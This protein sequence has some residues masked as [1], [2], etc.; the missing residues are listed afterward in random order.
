MENDPV[1]YR[2]EL[3]RELADTG[4]LG[5]IVPEALGGAAL[6]AIEVAIT[7]EELGRALCWT[8]HFTTAVLGAS[9]IQRGGA[10]AQQL[11][12][13][14]AVASGQAV[15]TTAWLEPEGGS[16]PAGVQM[17]AE[18]AGDGYR[19]SGT[20]ILVPF[21]ASATRLIT[22]ART[23]PGDVDVFLVDPEAPGLS[24]EPVAAMAGDPESL[25]RFD[26]VE[27]AAADR[28]PGGW[29]AWEEASTDGLIA[30]A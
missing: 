27:V 6:T 15:L 2:P 28:L 16:G 11:A 1:G 19:L 26:G 29:A 17:T 22:L 14:P 13:L 12:W 25:V 8:P 24:I 30:L 20:K 5:L 7:Y 4:L 10:E 23:G 18:P 21:A 3:W 9:L